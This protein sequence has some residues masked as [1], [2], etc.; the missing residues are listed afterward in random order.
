M[1]DAFDGPAL[2]VHKDALLALARRCLVP[3]PLVV[4]LVKTSPDEVASQL[5]EPAYVTDDCASLQNGL[6]SAPRDV[7]GPLVE[8][9]AREQRDRPPPWPPGLV[10]YARGHGIALPPAVQS[11]QGAAS[12]S[13]DHA[14]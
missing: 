13:R 5:F 14:R 3:A 10:R 2:A 7:V 6:E 9:W 8:R 4:R 12:E 11:A 1:I